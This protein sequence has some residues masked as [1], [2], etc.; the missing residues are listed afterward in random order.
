MIKNNDVVNLSYC[1]KNANGDELDRADK[2]QPFA[3]LHGMGQIVPGL[4]KSLDGLKV[5]DKKEVTVSPAEGYGELDPSLRTQAKRSN[6]PE[7]ADLKPGMQF[8]GQGEGGRKVIFEI[9][10]VEGDNINV[11]GNHPL[12]GQTLHF[13][14]EVTG[15]REATQEELT[16]GHAHGD[17][18]AHH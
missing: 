1:L 15:I 11:D 2:S 18:G 14:V 5:G 16:H 17:G 6:F 9:I 4:E 12:A 7:G 10:S 8:E 13:D 3:Y